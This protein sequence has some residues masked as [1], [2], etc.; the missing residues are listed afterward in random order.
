MHTVKGV[1][2]SLLQVPGSYQV[3]VTVL[4]KGGY[5]GL[6]NIEDEMSV[7]KYFN[8]AIKVKWRSFQTLHLCF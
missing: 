1:N 3:L 2:G 4:L 7:T 8:M 5:C 6:M